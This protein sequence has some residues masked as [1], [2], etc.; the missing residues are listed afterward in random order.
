MGLTFDMKMDER[1]VDRV[2]ITVRLTPDGQA[3]PIDGVAIE[4][5]SRQQESL[6][7]R[8][9]LPVSGVLDA[10][11]GMCVELRCSGP[12]PPGAMAVGTA[13]HGEEQWR[14]MCSADPWTDLEAHVRGKRCLAGS[15][16]DLRRLASLRTPEIHKFLHKFPWLARSPCRPPGE[17][18]DM[19]DIPTDEEDPLVQEMCSELGIDAENAEWLKELMSED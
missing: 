5:V 13:W 15:L 3:T 7:P 10:P 2:R 17:L 19:L 12:L 1:Q 6:S 14:A 18:P 4:L 16:A 8:R 9:L 11:L